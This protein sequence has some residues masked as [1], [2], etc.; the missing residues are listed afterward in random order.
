MR[1]GNPARA[2]QAAW[3][4]LVSIN[5]EKPLRLNQLSGPRSVLQN[6]F[7]AVKVKGLT[8]AKCAYILTYGFESDTFVKNTSAKF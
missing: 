6:V 7:E 3:R 2:T 8:V 1:S 4:V 5:F